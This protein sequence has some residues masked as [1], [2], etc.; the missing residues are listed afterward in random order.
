MQMFGPA[1]HGVARAVQE[2]VAEGTIPASEADDLYICVGVFI[3][4]EA[5][6]DAKIQQY[7]YQA[8]K[9]A[10]QRP[11][12]ASP[13]PQR[14]QLSAIRSSTPSAPRQETAP[15]RRNP[16]QSRMVCCAGPKISWAC[17]ARLRPGGSL[18]SFGPVA[19]P[20]TRL[21]RLAV[22][23]SA[24]RRATRWPPALRRYRALR[25]APDRP[26]CAPRRRPRRCALRRAP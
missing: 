21:A 8:T 24:T 23:A 20:R 25:G 13:A 1:Q 17:E 9:E 16:L 14:R 3:H 10:L 15:H 26:R 22:Q 2:C 7:N 12:R 18:R 19:C 4:W 5:A 6:D 11:S